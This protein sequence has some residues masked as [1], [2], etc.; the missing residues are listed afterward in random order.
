MK[1][2]KLQIRRIIKEELE[3]VLS[4]SATMPSR[5]RMKELKDAAREQLM[6]HSTDP[7]NVDSI[8]KDG[9][10]VGRESAQTLAGDWA[11]DFYDER[12]I[13]L[14]KEKGKYPGTPLAVETSGLDLVAD[15]PS[16]VDTDAYVKEEGMYWDKGSEPDQMINI[17]DEDGMVYFDDLLSPGSDAAKAAIEVT[18]TAAVLKNIP[19][20]RIQLTESEE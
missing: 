7:K 3:R 20:N 14:S 16:L 15:L 6:Y 5:S 19:P 8:Q 17:V 13:Y 11:D 12:P 1:F 9:L 10:L 4:E 2:T 18:G